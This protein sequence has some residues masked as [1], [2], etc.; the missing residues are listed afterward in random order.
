MLTWADYRSKSNHQG[1]GNHKKDG[2][3]FGSLVQLFC[4]WPGCAVGELEKRGE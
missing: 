1:K 2:V 4:Q 3:T